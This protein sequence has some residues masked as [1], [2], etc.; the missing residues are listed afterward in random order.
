MELDRKD[1]YAVLY[2]VIAALTLYFI[3]YEYKNKENTQSNTPVVNTSNNSINPM[4]YATSGA[5]T[6]LQPLD[7]N[8]PNSTIQQPDY[9]NIN[10]ILASVNSYLSDN[11]G[12]KTNANLISEFNQHQSF[13]SSNPMFTLNVP[14][15]INQITGSTNS[16]TTPTIQTQA[17]QSG[18]SLISNQNLNTNITNPTLS[19]QF[20]IPSSQITFNQ[21]QAN[22]MAATAGDQAIQKEYAAQ[23]AAISEA[24]AQADIA[25]SLA[26]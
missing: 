1:L 12:N 8:I 4:P 9:S 24:G 14:T 10:G 25:E 26:G 15:N 18:A 7:L 17:L 23:Q 21:A 5:S 19:S 3:Y 11:V 13:T 22:Q 6:T 20:F 16:I 2:I